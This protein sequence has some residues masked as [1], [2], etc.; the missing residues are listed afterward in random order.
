MERL[1]ILRGGHGLYHSLPILLWAILWREPCTV[2]IVGTWLVGTLMV[3]HRGLICC[4]RLSL[5]NTLSPAA[6]VDALRGSVS[7][8]ALA[9]GPEGAENQARPLPW[10]CIGLDCFIVTLHRH[11]ERRGLCNSHGDQSIITEGTHPP[12][13]YGPV[14][15]SLGQWVLAS[16]AFPFPPMHQ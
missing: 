13:I 4:R 16:Q 5:L 14:W 3:P 9:Q 6:L 2:L 11:N 8:A 12:C 1:F 15:A 7:Q 10:Q